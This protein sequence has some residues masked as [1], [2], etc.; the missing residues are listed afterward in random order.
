VAGAVWA[1]GLSH[2]AEAKGPQLLAPAAADRGDS[3][4][5]EAAPA[6]PS[7]PAATLRPVDVPTRVDDDAPS[8]I[9][10]STTTPPAVDALPATTTSSTTTTSTTTTTRPPDPL[11]G[12]VVNVHGDSLVLSAEGE[13]RAV[14]APARVL[15]DAEEGRTLAQAVPRI[16]DVEP[17][18]LDVVVLALGTNDYDA[19][20]GYP[21]LVAGMVERL[22]G[23]GCVVWVN[24]Q[25]FRYG[26]ETVNAAIEAAM[27]GAPNGVLVRWSAIADQ[28]GLHGDDGYHLNELGRSTYAALIG[29]GVRVCFEDGR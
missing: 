10:P 23:A 24:T 4:S 21:E 17:G 13:L 16:L 5:G 3:G 26:H 25:E 18:P 28:P 29:D 14:L 20:A 22:A 8:A 6:A 2:R 1:F 11:E 27:A 9:T 15:L 7:G 12:V 19:G